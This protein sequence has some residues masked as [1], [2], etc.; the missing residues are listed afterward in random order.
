MTEAL[1][2]KFLEA[3]SNTPQNG[4]GVT[5]AGNEQLLDILVITVHVMTVL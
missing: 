4:S 3:V 1:S 5:L 2:P